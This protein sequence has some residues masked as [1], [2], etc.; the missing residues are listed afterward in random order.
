MKKEFNEK[1]IR[2]M[3]EKDPDSVP[4]EVQNI[5][6]QADKSALVKRAVNNFVAELR[7]LGET[8]GICGNSDFSVS[9]SLKRLEQ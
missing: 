8:E 2:E 4:A 9:Y 6:L 3:L 7:E 5:Y 1:Q